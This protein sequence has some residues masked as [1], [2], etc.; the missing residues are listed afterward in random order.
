MKNMKIALFTET[1][2]PNIDGVVVSACNMNRVLINR[3]HSVQVFTTGDGPKR[4]DGYDVFRTRGLSLPSYKG[5]KLGIPSLKIM[6]SLTK[7]GVDVIHSR[8]PFTMGLMAKHISKILDVPIVGTFDTPVQDYVHY[9][10]VAGKFKP[11]REALSRLA[12]KYS[13]WYYNRCDLVTAPSGIIRDEL[14]KMGCEKRIEVLSNGVDMKRYRPENR[15]NELKS[16]FCKQGEYM[17][18]HVGRVTKEKDIDVLLRAAKDLKSRRV[19]FR[20]VIAGKGPALEEIRGLSAELG[21]S[22]C[23][24]FAGF[25]PDEDLPTYY[26]TADVFV[27]ASTVETQGIVMLEALASGTPVIGARAGAT[28][29]LVKENRN[30]LMFEAGNHKDAAERL[31]GVLRDEA[32]LKELSGNSRDSVMEHSLDGVCDK[33][34]SIYSE[35]IRK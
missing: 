22:D 17:I 16:R 8:G 11:S 26:A 6:E 21:L 23:V 25:V 3:G 27:T 10:P 5:Y 9:L 14:K 12:I 7:N 28:P 30:G 32:L 19:G 20:L 18:F 29:E 24:V 2:L 13:M 4:V 33:L 31:S 35:M 34:E 15:S 1:F